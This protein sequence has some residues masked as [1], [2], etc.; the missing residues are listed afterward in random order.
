MQFKLAVKYKILEQPEHDDNNLNNQGAYHRPTI[1]VAHANIRTRQNQFLRPDID[2]ALKSKH[3]FWT[4]RNTP[5]VITHIYEV[6]I[7]PALFA[8]F[9]RG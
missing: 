9:L 5:Q 2:M 4:A 8:D 6:A 7:L 1:F 3:S